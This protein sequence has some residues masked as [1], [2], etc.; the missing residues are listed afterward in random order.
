MPPLV[1]RMSTRAKSSSS[2]VILFNEKRLVGH[3]C[4]QMFQ[5]VSDVENYHQFV[6]YCRR[7]VVTLRKPTML[8]ANLV[9]G[10]QPLL[11]VSYTSHVTLV[12]PHLVT[13]V[14]RDTGMFQHL[15]TVWKLVP[16]EEDPTA[17][18]IDFAVSFA[19]V[20]PN[21]SYIAKVFLN[22]IV[23]ENVAAFISRAE[24]TQGP[25]SRP[26]ERLSVVV[27]TQNS[28]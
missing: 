27:N 13:A 20:N 4:S 10:F 25:P 14:C 8:S 1:A 3:S 7:S 17:C 5:V 21:H 11:N 18:V 15:K 28:S 22:S 9:V 24:Q 6:P 23:R 16:A 12:E 19:F 2:S 26:P